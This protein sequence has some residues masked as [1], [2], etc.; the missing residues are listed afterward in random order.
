[1]KY[2]VLLLSLTAVLV[3]CDTKSN[4]NITTESDNTDVDSIYIT[5]SITERI[6]TRIALKGNPFVPNNKIDSIT[7]GQIKT[8]DGKQSYLTIL[9]PNK[10]FKIY[11]K[12]DSTISTNNIG[13]SILNYLWKSNNEFIAKNSSIIF[14]SSPSDSVA[15]LFNNFR[16]VRKEKI[17]EHADKLTIEERELLYY[18]ND[19]RVYSFLFYFGRIIKNYPPKDNFFKFSE[20][21]S[22]NTNWAKTLPQNLLYKHEVSYLNTYDSLTSMSSFINYMDSQTTNKDLL[23]F[24]KAIYI[25]EIIESPSYWERHQKLFNSVTLQQEIDNEKTNI[26]ST[27]I[28][29]S[30]KSFFSSQKGIDAYNFTA[31]RVDGSQIRL[32]E[33]RGKIVF[34]DS[35]ASWCGPCIAHRPRVL[36]LAKKYENDPRVEVLMI[37]VD[38]S[39]DIWSKSLT[40]MNQQGNSGDLIIE[41]GMRTLYGNN[42]NIKSIPKYILIDQFGVIIKSDIAEPSKAVEDMIERELSKI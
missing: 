19:A 11:I 31:E 30:S 17:D 18:Q 24:L 34:I 13:D 5:E 41:N 15:R 2:I 9:R 6:I 38:A 10:D 35:W 1:M 39:K 33:L 29:K 16:T 28:N 27:L 8:K 37:S 14:G 12:S 40:K 36:E 22:N 21:I 32:E 20:N 25:C 42:F 7:I 23:A 26:Y 3:S 4:F